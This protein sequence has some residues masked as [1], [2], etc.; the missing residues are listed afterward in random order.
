MQLANSTIYKF[1]GCSFLILALNINIL[2]Q[3]NSPYSR[4]GIGDLVNHSSILNRG[5]G[6]A[7][8]SFGSE[9]FINITNPAS[10][11]YLGFN[12][13]KG[14]GN[15]ISFEVGS[16]FDSRTLNQK[17]PTAKYNS[18]NLLFNYMQLGMQVGKSGNWGITFGLIPVARENYKIENRKRLPNID[19][20]LTIFEG[21]G[22]TYRAL[23]GTGYRKNNFSFGI[24]TGYTFGKK[25][26]TTNRKLLNDS[27]VYYESTSNSKT[28]YG[29]VFLQTGVL[30]NLAINK[31]QSMQFGATYELQTK[32]RAK[33][34][35]E[36]LVYDNDNLNN[37]ASGID[38]IFVQKNVSGTI[39]MPGTLGIGVNYRKIDTVRSSDL[40]LAA[41]FLTTSWNNYRFYGQKDLV[42]SNWAVK[43]GIQWIPSK[44]ANRYWSRVHYRGGF[45]YGTDYIAAAGKTMP[46][47][48]VTLG[49]GLPIPT[50]ARVDKSIVQ[51]VVNLAFEA[52][53]RG[54]RNISLRENFVK[55]SLSVSLADIWFFRRKFD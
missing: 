28:S 11:S 8:I 43:T 27:I 41:D 31:T 23:L 17:N 16:E 9:R 54:D 26:I 36:R 30:Y 48:A 1:L 55:I 3:D 19:S 42:K 40:I 38:S 33:Q 6:G 45:N 21:S 44:I 22:G 32:L 47:Y 53:K 25:D 51:P 20:A 13:G 39:V 29:N 14:N 10:Y 18:K 15:L 37:P 7:S 24:N 35:V 4:Y 12:A 2:A 50:S 5:M 49:L 46:V 52:G 34:D